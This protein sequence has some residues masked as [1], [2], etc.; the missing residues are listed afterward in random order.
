MTSAARTSSALFLVVLISLFVGCG[1]STKPIAVQLTSSASALDQAQ[2][3]TLTASVTNDSKSAGVQWAVAGGGSLSNM[4]TTGAT[5]VAPSSVTSA[6]RASITATSISDPSKSASVQI[7]VSPLP[8]ITTTTVPA[9]TAGIGYSATINA[10]GGS[11]PFTWSITSGTLP[12]GLS[13]GASTGS[14]VTIVGT[15]TQAGTSSITI[16]VKDSTGAAASQGLTIT[17]QPPPAL[18]IKTSS[19]PAAEAGISYSQTL[20]ATGG[21]PP[22]QWTITSGSLPTGLTLNPSSGAISGTP[23]VVATSNFTVK[24]TD[25][26]TP[27]PASTTAN[28]SITVNNPPLQITTTTLP[29]GVINVTYSSTALL[30]AIGGTQPYTWSISSGSLPSGLMLN[31][32]TGLISGKP[33][34]A[35][36]S[37]FTAK[38]TDS[39]TPTAQ[40]A[41]ANLSITVNA[42]LA[43]STASLPSGIIG[44]AYSTTLVA[45]GGLTPYSWS[46]TTGSLPAGLSLNSTSGVISGTPTTAVT[47]NFTVTVSD[48]ETPADTANASLSIVIS[49]ASCPNNGNFHGHY[50]AAM[51][52]WNTDSTAQLDASAASFIADGAG[53]ITSGN[54]DT[55]DSTSG[56]QS[57]TFTGTYCLAANNLGT[58]TLKLGAPYSTTNTLAFTVDSTAKNG[59]IMFYDTTNTKEVGP[60]LQQDTSAFLTSKIDGDYAFGLVGVDGVGGA[61][62]FAVAGQ[63]SSDGKGNLSGIVDGDDIFSGVSSQVTLTASDLT[64][65]SNG[66]GTVT[67]NFAGGNMNFS[68]QFAFY[69]VSAT[70]VLMV[71]IDGPQT[72]H[73]LLVG[74]ALQ[75]SSSAFTDAALSGDAI[76][77]TESLTN[78]TEPS[79]SG[80]IASAS[81][82]G[83]QITLSLDQNVGGTVGT[84]S[85]SGAYSVASNG[86]VTLSGSGLGSNPPVLYLVTSNGG[87]VVGTDSAVSYGQFYPQVG[88][89]FTNSS[90]D[91][92]FTGGSNHPQDD[93]V[94]EELDSVSAD[95]N[96]RLT[97]TSETNVNGGNP[98]QASVSATYVVSSNGRVVV[99]ENGS[100]SAILYVVNSDQVLVI[101]VD[102]GDSNPKL[103]WWLQ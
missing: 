71:E 86:R 97:G 29:Q 39:S 68:L 17:V 79:I 78:G 46:L 14:S 55:T 38:V 85:G 44:T 83:T 59:R 30:T 82:N 24:V 95:G 33:T 69:V 64:V 43:V 94:S 15:P 62:R 103:S 53:N 56:H 99:T 50:S 25:S 80:G 84:F 28:L 100:E 72:G 4:S 76:V 37:S 58:M 2:T 63:F 18:A 32:S 19:L 66:R 8:G 12:A 3:A 20:Q 27:T 49:S 40:T 9:A 1:S 60:L 21:I 74:E 26:Q 11:G 45:S 41:T 73:P 92:A 98:S 7:E 65:A 96:G 77:G 88:S 51:E 36:T 22:Y 57:G 5:Y 91:G 47:S 10:S 42:A 93:L 52:G 6:F 87:F 16:M 101:P 81:G 61:N 67:L 34:A 23:T 75:Q 13:L 102:S 54:L 35:G 31:S 90:F 70:E 48:A 89:G